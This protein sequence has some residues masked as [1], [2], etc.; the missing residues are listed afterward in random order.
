MTD[1]IRSGW[2]PML[3]QLEADVREAFKRP[4]VQLVLVVFAV[5]KGEYGPV[6]LLPDSRSLRPN[7]YT[8]LREVATRCGISEIQAIIALTHA[9]TTSIVRLERA[10]ESDERK[11]S[12]V[13]TSLKHI[14][15]LD[16]PPVHPGEEN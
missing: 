1:D 4:Y 11:V 6:L 10:V 3:P 16:A 12:S 14:G 9:V 13:I 5:S 8:A 15:F 2:P 7:S